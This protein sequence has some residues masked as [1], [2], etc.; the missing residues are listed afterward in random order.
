[1]GVSSL[2]F[3]GSLLKSS[4]IRQSRSIHKSLKDQVPVRCPRSGAHSQ[5]SQDDNSFDWSNDIIGCPRVT[6]GYGQMS[7]HWSVFSEDVGTVIR[8]SLSFTSPCEAHL[9]L[10]T[11]NRNRK[12][13]DEI[14]IAM[15]TPSRQ[16]DIDA[17]WSWDAMLLGAWRS[18]LSI[19]SVLLLILFVIEQQTVYWISMTV[20][21]Q[22]IKLIDD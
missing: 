6:A 7:P 17:A 4:T 9:L 13:G 11:A 2:H 19:P 18:V 16:L 8:L 20:S 15:L 3:M 1:M 10:G 12:P 22:E 5:A 21:C 14:L